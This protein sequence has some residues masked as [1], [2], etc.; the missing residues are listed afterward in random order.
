MDGGNPALLQWVLNG[1]I[2]HLRTYFLCVP[3]PPDSEIIPLLVYRDASSQ[4][5]SVSSP[6][7]RQSTQAQPEDEVI[8]FYNFFYRYN[9]IM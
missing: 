3:Q 8:N 2:T 5:S 9:K 6:S 4:P 1:F 7:T